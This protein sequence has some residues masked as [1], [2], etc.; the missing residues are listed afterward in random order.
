MTRLSYDIAVL[1]MPV[2]LPACTSSSP[3]AA[4]D[5]AASISEAGDE[6]PP[7]SP[8]NVSWVSSDGGTGEF[9]CAEIGIPTF[10][11]IVSSPGGKLIARVRVR[12]SPSALVPAWLWQI[13]RTVPPPEMKLTVAALDQ[14]NATVS[15]PLEQPGTYRVVVHSHYPGTAVCAADIT[16]EA[17]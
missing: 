10:G 3:K 6:P 17:K 16:F 13:T 5:V 4:V 7:G 2:M 12:A 1:A 8:D 14:G 11:N 15:I 9:A